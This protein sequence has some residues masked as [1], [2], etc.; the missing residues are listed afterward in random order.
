MGCEKESKM[1]IE[2][3]R[4]RLCVC[5][6]LTFKSVTHQLLSSRKKK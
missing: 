3:T 6:F 4:E 5:V 2:G 1:I